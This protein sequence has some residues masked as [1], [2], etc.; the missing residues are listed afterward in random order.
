MLLQIFD[1]AVTACPQSAKLAFIAAIYQLT[2][3]SS[4]EEAALLYLEKYISSLLDLQ[5]KL[6]LT[7]NYVYAV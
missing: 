6:T 1:A 4:D 7:Y 3:D 5:G 2:S